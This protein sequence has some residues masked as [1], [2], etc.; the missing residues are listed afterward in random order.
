MARSY[1]RHPIHDVQPASRF[2]LMSWR[3]KGDAVSFAPHAS[4][5]QMT[6]LKKIVSMAT[7]AA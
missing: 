3:F 2:L 1:S 5:L 6:I 7:L 4:D